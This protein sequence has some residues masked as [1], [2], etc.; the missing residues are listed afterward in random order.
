MKLSKIKYTFLSGKAQLL[1]MFFIGFCTMNSHAQEM[2]GYANSNYAGIMGLHLNPASIVGVPYEYEVNV[3]AVDVFYDNNYMYLPK[4]SDVNTKTTTTEDGTVTNNTTFVVYDSPSDKHAYASGLILGPGYLKN[5]NK[6]AWAVHTAMRTVA[7]ANSIP[8][9]LIK[10]F[11]TDFDYGPLHNI[12]FKDMKVHAAAIAFGD[13][14]FTYSKVYLNHDAHWLAWGAT[15]KGI[16]A[17]DAMYLHANVGGYS[18][19]DSSSLSMNNVNLDYGHALATDGGGAMNIRGYGGGVDLGVVYVHKRNQGAY[20]CGKD[21]DRRKRYKYKVGVSLIDLGFV[22]FNRDASTSHINDGSV[23]WSYIDT[24]KFNSIAEFDQQLKARSRHYYSSDDMGLFMPAAASMQFDYCL[25]PRWYV[26]LGFVQRLP[27][28]HNEVYRENSIAL[29]PRYETRKF[30]ASFSA[31]MYEYE[32]VYLGLAFR[33]QF[34]VLGTDRLDSFT[35]SAV[36]SMDIFFG[37]KFNSC[38]LQRTHKNKKG[39]CPMAG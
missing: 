11:S 13:L 33:Y 25:K 27:F 23:R 15:L 26:N 1:L 14:G 10:G 4:L 30:E 29:V 12:A 18:I 21:A 31:N 35:G 32:H 19:P 34:F 5:K 6:S 39:A 17:F 24:A 7:S 9:A 36:R 16:V 28:A 8:S 3:L 2:W 37:F 38:M 22:K 20:E